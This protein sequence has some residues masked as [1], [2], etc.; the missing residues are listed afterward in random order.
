MQ[1]KV[2]IITGA[3]KGI[4]RNTA[5]EFAKAGFNLVVVARSRPELEDLCKELAASYQRECVVCS[6]DL[7]DMD[8]VASIPD[9]AVR[10]FGR[11]DVLV[12]NAAWRTIET[13]RTIELST[14]EKTLKICLTSPA[15][16]AQK[17]AAV[18]ESQRI[19]GAVINVSSVMAQKAGGN[20]PAYISCK[21]A[22]DSLTKE[23]AVT[24]G[25]SGI[26]FVCVKPGYIDTDLSSDYSSTTGEKVD[27]QMADELLD[28][29]PLKRAGQSD[30][31]A[32]A[33]RWLAS[34]E[35]TYLTGCELVI[36]GGLTT[37]FNSYR[38]KNIQF[39]NEY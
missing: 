11:I 21:G 36:D 24:Y 3:S 6:G 30:E 15:F 32:K 14:W 29:L 23:L 22:L 35:A 13:M 39:P 27:T 5:L 34:D 38:I 31:V 2:A 19:S 9:T 26:R 37:N 20:S 7:A 1:N 12:N 25:R 33:I 18:M 17:C 8:F 28:F 4:G 16:L 10:E